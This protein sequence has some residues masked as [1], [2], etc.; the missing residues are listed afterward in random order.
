[1][2]LVAILLIMNGAVITITG[3]GVLVAWLPIWLGILLLK[4]AQA[5]SIAY[6]QGNEHMLDLALRRLRTTFTIMGVS[7][8]ILLL[9]TIALAVLQYKTAVF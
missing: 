8:L 9:S 6:Q 7:T 5:I 3:I 4:T 2:R 1:M